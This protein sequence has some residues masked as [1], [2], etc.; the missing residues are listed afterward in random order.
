MA[1]PHKCEICG[2]SGWSGSMPSDTQMGTTA[3]LPPCGGCG[4]S[5]IV[6]EGAMVAAAPAVFVV[7]D[8][9]TSEEVRQVREL[10]KG[11]P[12]K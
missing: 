3:G 7:P 4:G 9:L 6:W 8:Q 5:G 10:L 12:C 2:G 1:I 11:E